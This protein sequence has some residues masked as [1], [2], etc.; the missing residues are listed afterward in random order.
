MRC[1]KY[2][3]FMRNIFSKADFFVNSAFKRVVERISIIAVDLI[4]FYCILHTCVFGNG[5]K[6]ISKQLN[7]VIYGRSLEE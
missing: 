2:P 5:Q 1:I 7:P 6:F 3:Q 4:S